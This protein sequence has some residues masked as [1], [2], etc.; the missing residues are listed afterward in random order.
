MSLKA[1]ELQIAV[2]RTQEV[3][4][5]MEHQ[6][7][8]QMHD[9]QYHINARAHEEMAAR[10]KTT[11]VSETVQG[12]IKDQHQRGKSSGQQAKKAAAA[13]SEQTAVSRQEEHLLRQDPFRGRH[14]DISL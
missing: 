10:Q 7:Q 8:R 9:Q 1:V 2:P 4:R 5:I 3:G 12:R 14:I 11:D 13:E 6:Q